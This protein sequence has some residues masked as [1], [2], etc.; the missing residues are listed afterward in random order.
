MRCTAHAVAAWTNANPNNVKTGAD[1][2]EAAHR[3]SE[4]GVVLDPLS[5]LD[6][7]VR[8]PFGSGEPFG[9]P[10]EQAQALVD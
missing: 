1:E 2:R 4:Q 10:N 7:S 5:E 9:E 6:R 8:V 3:S